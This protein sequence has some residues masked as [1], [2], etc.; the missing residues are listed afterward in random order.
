[1]KLVSLVITLLFIQIVACNNVTISFDTPEN[2]YTTTCGAKGGSFCSVKNSQVEYL[3]INLFDTLLISQI[4]N[5]RDP[6]G[7]LYYQ[8]FIFE[9][10]NMFA[11]D[12]GG[13]FHIC[14]NSENSTY[15]CYWGPNVATLVVTYENIPE[16]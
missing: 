8:G 16:L 9:S 11:Q 14:D 4:S 10:F 6:C 13:D 15:T 5:N 1:M 7:S 2:V 12:G 3:D